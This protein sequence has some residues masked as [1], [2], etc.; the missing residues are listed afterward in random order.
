MVQ[1]DARPETRYTYRLTWSAEDG[2]FIATC[3]EF[4]SLSWLA[5]SQ[6]EALNGLEEV[7]REVVADLAEQEAAD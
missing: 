3:A 1:S 7:L 6:I 2:E 4:P 5:S